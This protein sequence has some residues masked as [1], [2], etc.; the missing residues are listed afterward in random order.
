[1][2]AAIRDRGVIF[3]CDRGKPIPPLIV[4][5]WT[6]RQSY[7]GPIHIVCGPQSPSWFL[8]E[9]A[10]AA[11]RSGFTFELVTAYDFPEW[12]EGK[13]GSWCQKPFAIRRSPFDTT[14]YFDCDHLFLRQ[15]WPDELFGRI[16]CFGICSAHDRPTANRNRRILRD[17]RNVTSVSLE[18]YRPVNGGCIGYLKG[19][20][21][22]QVWIEFMK[23]FAR[24]SQSNLLRGL[25]EEFALGMTLNIGMGGWLDAAISR[26]ECPHP[27]ARGYHLNQG[28]YLQNATWQIE[29]RNSFNSDFLGVKVNAAAFIKC[30]KRISPI[31]HSYG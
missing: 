18:A 13:R 19:H 5:L 10:N 2:G 27:I 25:A 29:L 6:L 24:Q 7:S 30:D 4:A 17:L 8:S 26:M 20:D 3:Y 15:D 22:L 12:T 14:L 1:M 28:R 21:G 23:L 31:L 16:E 9:L 11:S